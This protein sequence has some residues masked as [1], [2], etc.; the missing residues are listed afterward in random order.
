MT[1]G[2][3]LLSP[4]L[5]ASELPWTPGLG[6]I[7]RSFVRFEGAR[8]RVEHCDPLLEKRRIIAMERLQALHHPAHCRGF[9][10]V[11]LRVLHVEV[12]DD[13]SKLHDGPV[14]TSAA[15]RQPP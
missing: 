1:H 13:L 7:H 8:E 4:T 9:R 11:V 5:I 12:V 10:W 3:L 14:L 6:R 2:F 15:T